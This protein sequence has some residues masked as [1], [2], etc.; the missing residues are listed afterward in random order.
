MNVGA[1]PLMRHALLMMCAAA[2]LVSGC[3]SAT[4]AGSFS[5]DSYPFS[6]NYPSSW[7]LSQSRAAGA[8]HGTVT[9]ALREPLDQVQLTSFTMKKAIPKGE[10]ANQSEIDAIVSRMVKQ[11]GGKA[12]KAREVEYGGVSG[13]QFTLSYPA[14]TSVELEG[15][16]TILFNGKTQ[17][18]VNCQSSAENRKDLSKGC[19]E[20]LDSLELD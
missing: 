17:V 1:N 11:D 10:N 2:A 16:V 8:D 4:G 6:F 15:R 7:T 5:S 12:G 19:D 18:S 3:G 14:S 20:I 13:F 9:V